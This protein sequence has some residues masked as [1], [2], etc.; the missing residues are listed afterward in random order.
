[1]TATNHALTGALIGLT[2]HN[3]WIALP[4]A[5]CSHIIC[6]IIPHF[7]VSNEYWLRSKSFA[8]YLLTDA[9]LCVL[10]VLSLAIFQPSFWLL[11]AVCAFVATSPDLLWI[12][13][14][15]FA[16]ARRTF[17][18]GRLEAFLSNIQWFQRPI[19]GFVELAWFGAATVLLWQFL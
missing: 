2:V 19:G 10:L 1:M 3:P 12:R 18:A 8:R 14:F 9:A 16:R 7:G 4:A 13:K 6:D 17:Q 15:V 5:F 11:A